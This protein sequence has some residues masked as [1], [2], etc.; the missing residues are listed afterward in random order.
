MRIV[1]APTTIAPV[2]T[3]VVCGDTTPASIAPAIVKT[4]NTDPGSYMS[5]TTRLRISEK[6][7]FG[8]AKFNSLTL[9]VGDDA[10]AR[11]SPVLGSIIRIEPPRAPVSASACA[12]CCSAMRCRPLS[13]VST[14]SAPDSVAVRACAPNGIGLPMLSR[15]KSSSPGLP[16]RIASK[17]NSTPDNPWL[18]RPTKPSSWLA[19]PPSV[20]RRRLAGV[21]FTPGSPAAVIVSP[22][23]NGT[24]SASR[25]SRPPPVPTTARIVCCSTPSRR[26][27]SS[28][29]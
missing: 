4:L 7:V 6:S 9:N 19:R 25:M 15:S 10:S 24:F 27:S 8:S 13:I 12:K 11:M 3:N 29:A 22:S 20:Y 26:D 16:A 5:V 28:T 18:S 23:A 17:S 1:R 2:S 21:T 14:K